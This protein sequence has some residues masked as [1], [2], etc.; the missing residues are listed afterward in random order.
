MNNATQIKLSIIIA[1]YNRAQYLQKS[2]T[3]FINQSINKDLYEIIVVDNNSTD[4]T[5]SVVN[6]VFADA[7]CS[8]KYIFEPNPG[9]H[10]ARNRGFIESR[11]KL[12]VFGDDDII[13]TQD[14]LLSILNEFEK[15]PKT[16]LIGGKVLPSWSNQPPY[17]IYDY[18]TNDVHCFFAYLNYGNSR[19]ILKSEYVFSN[20]MACYRNLI[21][22]I[23]GNA[24][25]TFPKKLKHLSGTGECFI[26]DGIR[27][28]GL[29]I[30]Y[31]PEALV[32]HHAD[33][34]RATLAYFIDRNERFAVEDAFFYFRNHKKFIAA[35]LLFTKTI[36]KIF[37]LHLLETKNIFRR[38]FHQPILPLA[39][40]NPSYFIIIEKARWYYL[41][42]HI[43]RVLFNKELYQ[44]ITK[45][46]YLDL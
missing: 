34:S 46:S 21:F 27:T 25:C 22:A 35:R 24:P 31:L 7:H 2:L 29:D 3:S 28:L 14:W 5:H 20:N 30:V 8:C 6:K 9:V 15:N 19:K 26:V 18:G 12:I 44:H 33:A 43:F 37:C 11:G 39:K 45:K 10:N 40:I 32:Y 1:T 17:W 38:F 36:K 41:F 16:G 42:I 23:G 4:D 13:A